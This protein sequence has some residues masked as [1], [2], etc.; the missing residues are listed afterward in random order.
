M[1]T[2]LKK[3]FSF[4]DK[5]FLENINVGGDLRRYLVKCPVNVGMNPWD[6]V[7]Q[8][9]LITL[10]NEHSLPCKPCIPLENHSNWLIKL[11]LV[12]TPGPLIWKSLPFWDVQVNT[13]ALVIISLKNTIRNGMIVREKFCGNSTISPVSSQK[14]IPPITHVFLVPFFLSMVFQCFSHSFLLYRL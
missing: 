2:A 8:P 12:P 11:L 3:L 6:V 14:L 7:I 9:V 5:S 10:R 1:H 13:E 4:S